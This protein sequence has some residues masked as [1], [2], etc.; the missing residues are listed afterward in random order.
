MTMVEPRVNERVG[1]ERIDQVLGCKRSS[2]PSA[3]P[4][5][6]MATGKPDATTTEMPE[7]EIAAPEKTDTTSL[8]ILDEREREKMITIYANI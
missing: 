3:F 7:K 4:T 8:A 1:P 5:S 2:C 6:E